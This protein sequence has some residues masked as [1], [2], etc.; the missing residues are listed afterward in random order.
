MDNDLIVKT[1]FYYSSFADRDNLK[2]VNKLWYS[3]KDHIGPTAFLLQCAKHN[4][5]KRYLCIYK[6]YHT[7]VDPSDNDNYA[8]REAS[9]NGH[10][11][12]VKLLLADPKVDPSASNNDAIRWASQNGHTEVVKLL[13]TDHRV[14]PATWNNEPIRYASQNGHAEVVKLLLAD[15]RV[16]PSAENNYAIKLATRNGHS[17]VVKLL[18]EYYSSIN[19][20][21]FKS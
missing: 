3:N 19:N 8:I 11:E 21:F 1:I 13:L 16:D 12:V 20:I 6:Y 2:Q 9:R 10:T 4:H 18:L 15:P 7:G 14:D 5:W 17:E